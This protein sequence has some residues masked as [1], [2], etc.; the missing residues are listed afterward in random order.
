MSWLKKDL[1]DDLVTCA[2]CRC[3]LKD[4][5]AIEVKVI[6]LGLYG[7]NTSYLTYC[8]RCKPPFNEVRYD[9]MSHALYFGQVQM[10]EKGEPVGY[11]KDK[12][13]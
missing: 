4:Y 9:D 10:N 11:I 8:R 5:N 7:P 1:R 3:Q 12:K 2:D 6:S 13:L